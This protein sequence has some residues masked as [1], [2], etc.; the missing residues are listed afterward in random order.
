[1]YILQIIMFFSI[2]FLVILG[3][4]RN[5]KIFILS[6]FLLSVY[7]FLGIEN[8]FR[9]GFAIVF[10]L[11]FIIYLLKG[12][13]FFA[14]LYLLIAESL[15]LSSF[16]FAVIIFFCWYIFKYLY[17][18][19]QPYYN[20]SKYKFFLFTFV[21]LLV[22]YIFVL[23]LEPY[24]IVFAT[25]NNDRLSGIL[26][27]LLILLTFII[28]SYFWIGKSFMHRSDLF[29]L[30]LRSVFFGL[31]FAF[32]L[33]NGGIEIASRIL[34]FYFALEIFLSAQMFQYRTRQKVGSVFILLSYSFAINVF[35]LLAQSEW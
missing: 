33:I 34:L 3:F 10:L 21:I 19:N 8:A 4:S 5:K 6:F 18:T 15:H 24:V 12:K 9:Q 28:S 32:S 30:Y 1:M 29:F 22:L 17:H 26:K 35:E 7:F 11:F 27:P 25:R 13:Y 16:V 14:L 31:F 20:L 2:V 23:I